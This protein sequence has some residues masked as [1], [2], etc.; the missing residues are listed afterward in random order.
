M[1]QQFFAFDLINENNDDIRR[2]LEEAG[3]PEEVIESILETAVQVR[4]ANG[5][6]EP[7]HSIVN[8]NIES[9]DLG[10]GTGTGGDDTEGTKI[11]SITT[12]NPAAVRYSGMRFPGGFIH[13]TVTPGPGAAPTPPR[14]EFPSE[15][16]AR[17][18]KAIFAQPPTHDDDGN[19]IGFAEDGESVDV[20]LTFS[21]ENWNNI[22]EAANDMDL[23]IEE[24]FDAA[25]S[26]LLAQ[27]DILTEIW[28]KQ[29]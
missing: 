24:F 2:K 11:G 7:V 17:F 19:F 1:T 15:G 12:E 21:A 4:A 23:T 26:T 6:A 20:D 14:I 18:M 16:V 9:G 28:E 29:E 13:T 10:G 3:A 25:V 27:R 8:D 22:R 5:V